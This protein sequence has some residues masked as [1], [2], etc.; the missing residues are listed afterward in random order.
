MNMS[1]RWPIMAAYPPPPRP[2]L[3][4]GDR[5]RV[6]SL[7]TGPDRAPGA[8][9]GQPCSIQPTRSEPGGTEPSSIGPVP[10]RAV[11]PTYARPV[12]NPSVIAKSVAPGIFAGIVTQSGG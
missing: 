5:R 10:G 2:C 8:G 9:V 7:R 1:P 3:R 11:H 4:L 12:Q 6:S